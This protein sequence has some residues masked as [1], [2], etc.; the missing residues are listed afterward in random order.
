MSPFSAAR[1]ARL[2]E[3]LEISEIRFSEALAGPARIDPEY[4]N[5]AALMALNRL[6]DPIPLGSLVK[7]GYRVVYESTEAIERTEGERLGLPYFLQAADIS[8]PFINEES[9]VCVSEADWHRYP[10]GRVIPGE[11]LIEVKG[12]AEKVALVPKDFP[13]KTLVTGTCYKL[14]THDELD[15][16]FLAAYLTCGYGQILKNRLKT[17]LLVSYLA[18]DDL[19]RLAVPNVSVALKTRIREVFTQ[20]AAE[21]QKARSHIED[22]EIELLD[23]LGL[24]AWTAPE[25]LSYVRRSSEAFGAERF[26]AEYFHPQKASALLDLRAL[27]DATVGDLF[28]SVRQLW[29]PDA[30]SPSDL[31]RNYDLNDALVPFLN[32][33]KSPVARGEIAST[34]KLLKAGDL[35]ASRLRSYL[36][37]IA[38]VEPSTE[39]P[40]VASTEYIVL[41]PNSRTAL[42]VEALLVYL[43]SS[44]P[45]IVLKWSQ[46]GSNHPRFDEKEILRMPVPRELVANPAPY[47]N[48]MQEL[49]ASKQRVGEL[50]A[51]MTSA[52]EIAIEDSE[53]AA[54]QYLK[55]FE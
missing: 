47:V 5:R 8:T 39:F 3:G 45:Q 7:S 33:K 9:M 41:R 21:E 29:Q 10:K 4:F 23:V 24:A 27:S 19:Y 30:G 31:V 42:P 14:S 20:C 48:A 16:Y 28:S 13:R 49:K 1:Y 25:P 11:L 32:G 50:L 53:V 17:N 35:V 52:I 34:K 40:M 54:I 37:E 22:A 12:K 44:L 38:I 36:R 55:S 43:R 46:D 26:D 2:L 51:A 18:K 15:Q 6:Q